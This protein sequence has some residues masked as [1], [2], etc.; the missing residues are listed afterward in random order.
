MAGLLKLIGVL[1]AFWIAIKFYRAYISGQAQTIEKIKIDYKNERRPYHIGFSK[2]MVGKLKSLFDSCLSENIPNSYG[3]TLKELNPK[4]I[5]VIKRTQATALDSLSGEELDLLVKIMDTALEI[6]SRI[7]NH[8]TQELDEI[9][10]SLND[11]DIRTIMP[12]IKKFL[13]IRI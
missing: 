10:K 1:I 6:S 9:Q 11:R 13:E 7:N 2:D 3:A 8:N 4:V 5:E 12:D